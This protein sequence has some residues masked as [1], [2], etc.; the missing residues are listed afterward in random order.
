MSIDEVS[1]RNELRDLSI[2]THTE[3]N[4]ASVNDISNVIYATD[5]D[6][7]MNLENSNLDNDRQPVGKLPRKRSK[8]QQVD[9][10]K[11]QRNAAYLNREKGQPY[12]GPKGKSYSVSKAARVIGE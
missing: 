10:T 4:D 6:K 12:L 8:R 2:E 7:P 11:W 5:N 1:D 9:L 3:K